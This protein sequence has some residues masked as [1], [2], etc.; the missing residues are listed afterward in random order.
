MTKARPGAASKLLEQFPLFQ[1]NLLS[2]HQQNFNNR[3]FRRQQFFVKAQIPI[4][5][6]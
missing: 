2:Q 6:E 1:N 3:N 5:K 4:S